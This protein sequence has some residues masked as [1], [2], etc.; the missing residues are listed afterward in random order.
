MTSWWCCASFVNFVWGFY[1]FIVVFSRYITYDLKLDNIVFRNQLS[2]YLTSVL[3]IQGLLYFTID[4]KHFVGEKLHTFVAVGSIV[5]C[6]FNI[7]L[8]YVNLVAGPKPRFVD[9]T[10][11]TF[12]VTGANAGI[13]LE[14]TK[15]LAEMNAHVI[16]GECIIQCLGVY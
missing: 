5:I 9:L 7:F 2:Q 1:L 10:G 8:V 12:I 3:S 15:L 16:M 14:T 11:K 13:G 4:A 6:L